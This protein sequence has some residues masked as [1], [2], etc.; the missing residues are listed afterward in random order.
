MKR[1]ITITLVLTGLFCVSCEEKEKDSNKDPEGN[2]TV[3]KYTIGSYYNENGVKGIVYEINEDSTKGMIVSMDETTLQW[4]RNEASAEVS[5]EA[6]DYE[7]GVANM[8]K[9]KPYIDN[10]P[11]FKWCNDKG[12]GWYLPALNELFMISAS[13][14]E[15]SS[16]L[17]ANGGTQLTTD[18]QYWSSTEVDPSQPGANSTFAYLMTFN[19]MNYT[20]STAKTGSNKVRAIRAF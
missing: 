7:D 9:I 17:V 16:S 15:L 1:L 11:A 4:A 6:F 8:E 20:S 12:N 5:R 14:E 10:Y 2:P 19:S 3:K 13:R 18:G